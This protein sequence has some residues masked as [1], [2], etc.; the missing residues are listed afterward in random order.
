M[1]AFGVE[2]TPAQR[3]PL[4]I[5]DGIPA[6]TSPHPHVSVGNPATPDK[7]MRVPL[8]SRLGASCVGATP[9]LRRAGA[10]RD[11]KTAR[12]V[13]GV[14]PATQASETRALV[15]LSASSSF[16]EGVAVTP[17]AGV[18][19]LAKGE[20]THGQQLLLIWPEGGRVVVEDPG[21]EEQY[22]LFRTGEDFNWTII[23][24]TG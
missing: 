15:L 24:P 23:Q 16:P 20:T 6:A 1:L 13:L 8:T 21:R 17:R 22:E 7:G 9:L 11:P 10:Y 5:T 2:F 12:V 3:P 19:L 18:G 14:E 4:R